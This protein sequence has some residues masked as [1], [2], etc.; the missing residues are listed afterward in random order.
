MGR[1]NHMKHE[2]EYF[3]GGL[4]LNVQP[5]DT[6]SQTTGIKPLNTAASCTIETIMQQLRTLTLLHF[7]MN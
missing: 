2:Y 5:D 1:S 7:K 4:R 6:M 3:F